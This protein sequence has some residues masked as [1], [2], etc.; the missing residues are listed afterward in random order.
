MHSVI[1]NVGG[2]TQVR[3][4]ENIAVAFNGFEEIVGSIIS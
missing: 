4:A 3:L 1:C 2:R